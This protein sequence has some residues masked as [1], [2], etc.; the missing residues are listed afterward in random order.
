MKSKVEEVF[1]DILIIL[2]GQWSS[3]DRSAWQFFHGM[4]C[5]VQ[6]REVWEELD[7]LRDV[8]W[9]YDKEAEDY[10]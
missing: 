9:I 8:L 5:A 2:E 4:A 10:E 7:L 6:D 1:E 3:R